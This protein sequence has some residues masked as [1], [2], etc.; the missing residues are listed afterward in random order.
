MAMVA[1]EEP[2]N[3]E[4][5]T[6]VD[7]ALVLKAVVIVIVVVEMKNIDGCKLTYLLEDLYDVSQLF[8]STILPPRSILKSLG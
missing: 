3:I 5:E 2:V 8:L 4:V 6:V 1:F 7:L